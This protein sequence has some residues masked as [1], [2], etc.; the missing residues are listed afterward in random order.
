MKTPEGPAIRIPEAAGYGLTQML[1]GTMPRVR[2][3]L[4]P[5]LEFFRAIPPPVLVPVTILFAASATP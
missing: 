5:V 4:E 3:V 2:A 1:V